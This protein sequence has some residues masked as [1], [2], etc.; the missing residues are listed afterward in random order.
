M[1]ETH[2][3]EKARHRFRKF[4]QDLDAC[5]PTCTGL[6][7]RDVDVKAFVEVDRRDAL[8]CFL[9]ENPSYET[10]RDHL[11]QVR[12]SVQKF[13]FNEKSWKKTCGQ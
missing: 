5:P 7:E 12:G 4:L 6:F 8:N 11:S 2:E 1:S 10:F 3:L 9:R 13:V